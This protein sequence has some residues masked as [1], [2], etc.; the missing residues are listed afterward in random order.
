MELQT[1]LRDSKEQ[2]VRLR[3][4]TDQQLEEA[5][6]QWDDERRE[7]SHNADEAIRV[8]IASHSTGTFINH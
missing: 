4:A 2:A 5:N 7:M 1:S 8:S 3:E 6:A